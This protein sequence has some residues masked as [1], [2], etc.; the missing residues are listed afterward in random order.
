[1]VIEILY[2]SNSL[3]RKLTLWKMNDNAVF[4]DNEMNLSDKREKEMENSK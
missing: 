4:Y 3:T 1:M 2:A